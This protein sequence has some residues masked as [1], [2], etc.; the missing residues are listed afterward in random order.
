MRKNNYITASGMV[1]NQ[2]VTFTALRIIMVQILAVFL[3]WRS[4]KL[5]LNSVIRVNSS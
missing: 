1:V 3:H 5:Y 4:L 2:N